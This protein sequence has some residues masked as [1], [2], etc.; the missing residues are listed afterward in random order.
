[1]E[2]NDVATMQ[3][4]LSNRKK[5]RSKKKRRYWTRPWLLKRP[6]LGQYDRLVSE[7]RNEDVE[8]FRKFVR[9]E[10]K[11]FGELLA[12]FMH[13]WRKR[14]V[15][16]AERRQTYDDRSNISMK[17]TDSVHNIGR[18]VVITSRDSSRN[19]SYCSR[20]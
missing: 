15:N 16:V 12:P 5:V 14:T 8:A 18:V 2:E 9:V 10:S 13:S 7:L 19:R 6:M 20:S 3:Q 4:V 17:R 11:M 1:M